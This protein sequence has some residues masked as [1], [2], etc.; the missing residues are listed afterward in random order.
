MFGAIEL[1]PV[2]YC[3]MERLSKSVLTFGTFSITLHNSASYLL[4]RLQLP[5]PLS[6]SIFNKRKLENAVR[7]N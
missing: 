3:C 5:P 7:I 2:P 4:K 6:T 1:L